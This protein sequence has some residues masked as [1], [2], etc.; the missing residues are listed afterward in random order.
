ME[1]NVFTATQEQ[2][3]AALE[4]EQ[5]RQGTDY[6]Q[7]DGYFCCLGV[8]TC[9]VNPNHTAL[10]GTGWDASDDWSDFVDYDELEH[11][12]DG[13]TAPPDVYK[14]LNLQDSTGTFRFRH[15]HYGK[16]GLVELN[17]SKDFTFAEI[18]AFI[19]EKPWAVFTNFDA[20]EV[21]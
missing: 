1:R 11:T 10:F 19:R 14:Q 13:Q 20:P 16:D 8:A 15:K 3:L 5:W 6:L 4:G 7:R 21:V 12:E 2:W 18:A 17:D 9:L